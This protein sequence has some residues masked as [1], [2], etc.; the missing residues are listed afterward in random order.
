[1]NNPDFSFVVPEFDDVVIT[2]GGPPT[3]WDVEKPEFEPMV[4]ALALSGSCGPPCGCDPPDCTPS[5]A[6]TGTLVSLQITADVDDGSWRGASAQPIDDERTY[7]GW[8]YTVV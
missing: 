4:E 7:F 6:E 2:W 3:I 8:D 1:M 5:G